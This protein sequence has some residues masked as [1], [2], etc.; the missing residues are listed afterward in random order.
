[1]SVQ[2]TETDKTAIAADWAKTSLSAL[3]EV[4]PLVQYVPW[5]GAAAGTLV[6]VLEFWDV[7]FLFYF[8]WSHSSHSQYLWY[9]RK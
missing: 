5:L 8:F 7:S 9:D 4:A 2:P 1:M 3:K 6:Q